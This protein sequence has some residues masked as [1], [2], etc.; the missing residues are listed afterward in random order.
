MRANK[1][2]IINVIK[3]DLEANNCPAGIKD[4][5]LNGDTLSYCLPSPHSYPSSVEDN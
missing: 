2:T 4:R 3:I 1:Y 5:C